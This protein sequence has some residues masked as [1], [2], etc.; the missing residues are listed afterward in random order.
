MPEKKILIETHAVKDLAKTFKLRL[1][2]VRW[3]CWEGKILVFPAISESTG[4]QGCQK[5]N[6][7]VKKGKKRQ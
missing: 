7:G 4:R 5:D 2:A 1:Y 6:K 3:L